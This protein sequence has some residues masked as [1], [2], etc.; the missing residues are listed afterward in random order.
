MSRKSGAAM[1]GASEERGANFL[2][3][4]PTAKWPMNL[5]SLRVVEVE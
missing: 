5:A 4:N 1:S 3:A 2:A